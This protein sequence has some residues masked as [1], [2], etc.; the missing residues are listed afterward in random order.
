MIQQIARNEVEKLHVLEL[1][2]IEAVNVHESEDDPVNYDCSVLLKGRPTKDGEPLKLENVPIVTHHTGTVIPPYVNDL[3]LLS[4]ING[5]FSMPVIIGRLYSTEKRVPIHADG[6]HRI[7][8]DPKTYRHGD[9]DNSPDGP[10]M[11][12]RIIDFQGMPKDGKFLHEY[13]IRFKNG[14]M[15]RYDESTVDLITNFLPKSGDDGEPGEA[16]SH[17]R[18]NGIDGNEANV[19]LEAGI[20]EER[21]KDHF[22]KITKNLSEM[23]FGQGDKMAKISL[24]MKDSA[25]SAIV[26]ERGDSRISIDTEEPTGKDKARVTVNSG[27]SKIILHQDGNI[28]I[29]TDEGMTIESGGNMSIN[30]KGDMELTAENIRMESRAGTRIGSDK[31]LE[32]KAG[33]GIN[34][35]SSSALGLKAGTAMKMEAMTDMEI[36]AGLTGKLQ[37]SSALTIKGLPVQIN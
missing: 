37:A 4:F 30:A 14:T 32:I 17:M 23:V 15:V 16:I 10:R 1:G 22:R 36:N 24:H 35:E 29:M 3:V 18:L 2:V 20:P 8:F 26:L 21:P 6:E 19:I 34:A 12:R 13:L 28:E 27:T 31:D 7:T 5:N 25:R 33:T 11:D 9:D